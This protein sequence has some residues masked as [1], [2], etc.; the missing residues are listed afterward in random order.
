MWPGYFCSSSKAIFVYLALILC[1]WS[2]KKITDNKNHHLQ[3][4]DLTKK[5][6]PRTYRKARRNANLSAVQAIKSECW[7][8]WVIFRLSR[9]LFRSTGSL[10]YLSAPFSTLVTSVPLIR[11]CNTYRLP[12]GALLSLQYPLAQKDNF[13]SLTND[14]C[15]KLQSQSIW[16]K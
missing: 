8:P 16:Y 12:H 6:L 5:Q 9:A 15:Q 13:Y 11:F 1:C 14:E 7:L 10:Q 4:A 3:T 2:M